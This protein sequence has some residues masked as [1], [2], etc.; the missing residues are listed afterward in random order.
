MKTKM[1]LAIAAL[2]VATLVNGQN[3]PWKEEGNNAN[4]SSRLG[5]LNNKP[6]KIFTNDEVRMVVNAD[7][8]VVVKDS[9]LVEGVNN[10][11]K[12]K[13][14]AETGIFYSPDSFMYKMLYVI[15]DNNVYLLIHNKHKWKN[16]SSGIT[17]KFHM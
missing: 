5:T 11:L 13:I 3:K 12:Q 15:N 4:N 8:E 10:I 7:G 9:L 16:C 2:C 1:L 17:I 6:L 14:P